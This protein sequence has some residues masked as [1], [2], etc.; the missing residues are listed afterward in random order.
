MIPVEFW[1]RHRMLPME[2]TPTRLEVGILPDTPRELLE[3]IRL[4]AGKDVKPILL[5]KEQL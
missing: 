3:D 5:T 1:Q 4:Q 2:D